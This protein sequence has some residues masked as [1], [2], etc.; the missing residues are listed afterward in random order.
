LGEVWR[1]QEFP[2]TLEAPRPEIFLS[3][4]PSGKNGQS[5]PIDAARLKV[6]NS[7]LEIL[8]I[9]KYANDLSDLR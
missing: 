2:N 3:V 9:A 1:I 4:R 7:M 6:I 5:S 8:L